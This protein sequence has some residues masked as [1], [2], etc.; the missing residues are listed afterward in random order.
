MGGLQYFVITATNFVLSMMIILC[1]INSNN[2]HQ[3]MVNIFHI[4]W[5][6]KINSGLLSFI[7][8]YV[9]LS[10]AKCYSCLFLD[11]A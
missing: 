2:W 1:K 6:K 11:C 10:S 7:A 5:G 4:N 9:I 8:M 3:E